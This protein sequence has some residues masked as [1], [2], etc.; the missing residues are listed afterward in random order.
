MID[1]HCHVLWGID[2]G[3]ED[4]KQSVD[5]CRTL[6][7]RGIR[8]VIATPHYIP[9]TTFNAPPEVVFKKIAELKSALAGEAPG[10]DIYPGME[11]FI[12]PELPEL[13]KA[14]EVLPLNGTKYLLVETSL[15]NV[16]AFVEDVI[17]RLQVDGYIPVLAHPERYGGSMDVE[18]IRGYVSKGL[19]TQVNAGSIDGRFGKAAKAFALKLLSAGLVHFAATDSH[20]SS[21]RFASVEETRRSLT[22]LIG[23]DNAHKLLYSNPQRLVNNEDIEYPDPAPAKRSFFKIFRR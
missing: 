8:A 10:L 9:G 12:T 17:F 15:N 1:I 11:L 3:P 4:M 23:G 19:L 13:L 18:K 22:G 20:G 14:K 7:E 21:R 5:S 2:D 6:K 16:P